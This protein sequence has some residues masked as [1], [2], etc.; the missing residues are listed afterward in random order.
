MRKSS[1][2]PKRVALALFLC[3]LRLGL[4]NDIL[5]PLFHFPSKRA[6][7][8]TFHA[9]R[10]SLQEQFVPKRIGFGRISRQEIIDRHSTEIVK[11]LSVT[12]LIT[13]AVSLTVCFLSQ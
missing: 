2:Q 4:T 10:E 8:R 7:S 13:Y 6:I 5:T 1:V 9:V 3:K 12:N 11:N